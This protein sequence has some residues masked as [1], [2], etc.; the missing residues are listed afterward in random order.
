MD[1]A[2][3]PVILPANETTD[4]TESLVS[5][6]VESSIVDSCSSEIDGDSIP[7]TFLLAKGESH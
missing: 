6:I 7:G 4:D 5:S 1:R 2:N 3:S